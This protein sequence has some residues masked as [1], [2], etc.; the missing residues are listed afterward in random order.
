MVF[1]SPVAKVK[2]NSR[3]NGS[4]DSFLCSN[5]RESRYVSTQN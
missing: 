2:S 4:Q 3:R 5:H 1:G